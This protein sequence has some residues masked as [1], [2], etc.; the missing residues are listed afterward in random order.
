VV[1]DSQLVLQEVDPPLATVILNRPDRLN[2]IGAEM[3]DQLI[4]AL[5]ALDDDP[6]V[7]CIIFT[8]SGRA[9]CAGGDVNVM[10]QGPTV[11]RVLH[12]DLHLL[13]TLS[14][15]ETPIIAMVNGPAIGLGATLALSCDL[16]M[17][18]ENAQIGDTHVPLGVL[19]GDGAL[20]P[21]LLKAGPLHT[22]DLLLRGIVVSGAEAAR[23]GLVNHAVSPVDLA[24]RTLELANDLASQPIYALRATKQ[25]INRYMRWAT[26]WLVEPAIAMELVSMQSP[27]YSEAMARF[28]DGRQ[29][30]DS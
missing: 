13:H 10:G 15:L 17:I 6:E 29:S 25:V 4:E 18:A 20:V 23:S 9:F 12:R 11:T 16:V 21:L 28:H 22:K 24:G 27:E 14:A 5:T 2:A 3:T 1:T 19:A 7:R 30:D 26:D 8:G